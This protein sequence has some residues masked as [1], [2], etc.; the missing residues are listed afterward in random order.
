MIETQVTPLPDWLV[1]TPVKDPV[2]DFFEKL[3]QTPRD[4]EV[5]KHGH[6]RRMIGVATTDCPISAV[7]GDHNDFGSPVP[8]A[9][10][11]GMSHIDAYRVFEAAQNE[12]TIYR[13]RLLE[14]CGLE[15]RHDS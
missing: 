6:I 5:T 10:G 13:A 1:V 2:D 12:H 3:S 15:E 4:W 9:R 11:I 8:A 14:A 7:T